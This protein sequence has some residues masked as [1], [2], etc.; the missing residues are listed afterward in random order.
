MIIATA[1]YKIT[2]AVT[3]VYVDHTWTSIPRLRV[4]EV[5]DN[6]YKTG[7]KCIYARLV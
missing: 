1:Q 7:E 5:A 4:G 6:E 2:N 3:R